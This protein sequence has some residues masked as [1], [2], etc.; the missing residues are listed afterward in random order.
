MSRLASLKQRH[1]ELRDRRWYRWGTDLL[2]VAV[3]IVLISAWQTRGHVRDVP[4]PELTLQTLD[5]EPLA[6]GSLEGKPTL[7]AFWA[8][9]C[10][11][12]RAES[13][14]ISWVQE[15]AGEKA[16]VLSVVVSYG[17][18]AEVRGYVAAQEVDY[19]VLLAG[20]ALAAELKVASYPTVYFLDR[21]GKVKGS[22]VGYTTTLGL[23]ARLF[24]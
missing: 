16:N 14:N 24:L 12:C 7:L 15:L 1:A 19:P 23:L 5:G 20:D 4:L 13:P 9:W 11:V 22:A 21:E 8:P 17:E 6:L 2:L 10:G 3:A 18:L